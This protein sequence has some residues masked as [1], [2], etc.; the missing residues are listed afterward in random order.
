MA[1]IDDK[2]KTPEPEKTARSASTPEPKTDAP[3][4]APVIHDWA[5]I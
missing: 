1:S 3:K 5:S 2:R 4:P